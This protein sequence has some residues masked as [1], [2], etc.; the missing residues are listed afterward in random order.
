MRLIWLYKLR[1]YRTGLNSSFFRRRSTVFDLETDVGN[2]AASKLPNAEGIEQRRRQIDD[3]AI[4]IVRQFAT[5]LREQFLDV[6][7]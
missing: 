4:N 7:V 5:V 3:Y 1:S 2:F 6:R